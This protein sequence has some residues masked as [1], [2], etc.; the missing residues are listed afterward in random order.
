MLWHVSEEDSVIMGSGMKDVH[1]VIDCSPSWAQ[2]QS[3][4]STGDYYYNAERLGRDLQ[5]PQSVPSRSMHNFLYPPTVR[6]STDSTWK[7]LEVAMK[8][9]LMLTEPFGAGG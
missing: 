3:T 8:I 9:L 6:W 5:S 7:E 4:T 2:Y 1:K